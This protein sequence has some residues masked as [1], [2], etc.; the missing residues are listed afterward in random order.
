MDFY[1][2]DQNG[3]VLLPMLPTAKA[4]REMDW[5]GLER[6]FNADHPHEPQVLGRLMVALAAAKEALAI[7]SGHGYMFHLAEGQ[8]APLAAWPRRLYHVNLAP[9]G[10]LVYTE[11]EAEELGAGWFDSLARAQ[12]WDGLET[13]FNGRGGIAKTPRVPAPIY[14][15]KT[16]ISEDEAARLADLAEFVK[17]FKRRNSWDAQQ[18][19]ETA[20]SDGGGS[21][22]SEIRKEGGCSP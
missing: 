17:D 11:R 18:V 4:L 10:R 22:Q 6:R 20:Q 7:M 2:S 1:G 13:Q 14:D 21:P 16:Y 15:S 12:F 9:N 19:Q 8:G 5:Q 3:H